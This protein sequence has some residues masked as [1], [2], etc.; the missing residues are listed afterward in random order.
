MAENEG[1]E[2]TLAE[3]MEEIKKSRDETMKR[4][5]GSRIA[6]WITPAAFGGSI[7]LFGL[8]SLLTVPISAWNV[9]WPDAVIMVMGLGFM[10]WARSMAIRAQERF[11][12]RW[13]EPPP[14]F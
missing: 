14:R 13:H 5:E 11:R 12:D 4:I 8:A 2:P 9:W 6:M 3:I 10:F 1:R 7:T